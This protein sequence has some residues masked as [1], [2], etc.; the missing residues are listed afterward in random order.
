MK[1]AHIVKMDRITEVLNEDLPF[2]SEN[3]NRRRIPK[4]GA[5]CSFYPNNLGK[6]SYPCQELEKDYPCQELEKEG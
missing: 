4:V 1:G 5:L 6:T 3:T 2:Y